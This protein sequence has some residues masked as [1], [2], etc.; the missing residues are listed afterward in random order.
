ML[1][2]P[3]TDYEVECIIN[4]LQD[5]LSAGLDDIPETVI[6][7][8]VNFIKKKTVNLYLQSFFPNWNFS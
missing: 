2:S 4:G 6:E 8:S 3:V 5:S 7:S 1:V